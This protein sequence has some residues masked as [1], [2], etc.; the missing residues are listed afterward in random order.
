ML[1]VSDKRNSLQILL[2][3]AKKEESKP[4]NKLYE[5]SIIKEKIISEKFSKKF[6]LCKIDI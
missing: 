1:I 5:I 4:V 3:Y 2:N 6:I